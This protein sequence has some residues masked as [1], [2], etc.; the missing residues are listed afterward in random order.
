MRTRKGNSL[1]MMVFALALGA[2]VLAGAL[3]ARLPSARST[4]AAPASSTPASPLAEALGLTPEQHEQMR[5]IW[6]GVRESMR[7]SFDRAQE[8][9]K[10]RDQ[11]VFA[12]LTPEQQAAYNK[13]T[14]AH[15][16]ELERLERQRREL[17]QNAVTRTKA[18]LNGTQR[19]KYDAILKDRGAPGPDAG[20]PPPR[21]DI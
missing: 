2:G 17:F 21:H 8:L 13:I 16:D 10:D 4:P 15:R 1:L 12:L 20:P 11:Q 14:R 3:A 9:Q 5:K 7:D 19:Q 6:E 18:M